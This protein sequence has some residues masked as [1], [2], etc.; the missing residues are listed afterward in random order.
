VPDILSETVLSLATA[1]AELPP[2][3]NGKRCH[4][5]TLLRWGLKGLKSPDGTL[6]RLEMVRLGARWV[7]SREALTRFSNRLTPRLDKPDT[8]TPRAPADRRRASE[9]AAKEL[10]SLGI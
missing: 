2:A 4:L 9:R 8:P 7:T 1:A 5:S 6:V 3:R 10:E